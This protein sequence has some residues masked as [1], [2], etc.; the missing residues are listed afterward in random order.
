V[1]ILQIHELFA[2]KSPED[3]LFYLNVIY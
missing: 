2:A 1:F 3:W